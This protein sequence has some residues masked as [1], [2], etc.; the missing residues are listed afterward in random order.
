MPEGDTIFRAARALQQ[1]LGGKVIR[2][3]RSPLPALRGAT[4]EGHTITRVEAQGKNLV[5]HF[6]DGRSILSH[7]R[8]TGSWH[9]Y[10]PGER[11]WKPAHFARGVIETDDF[12]AVCF[13]APVFE[14][15]GKDGAAHHPSLA[16][17]GPDLLKPDFDAGEARRRLRDRN[18]LALGE[19]VMAQSA[20]AG[21]GNIFKSETLF[22]CKAN[23]FAPVSAFDDAALDAVVA[24]ARE[25]MKRNTG[26]G[27]RVTRRALAGPRYWVYRRSGEGCLR[28]GATV[29]MRRQGEAQRST[30]FCPQC[31]GVE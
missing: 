22:L 27:P 28:C 2:A 24:K 13:N 31:Q 20:I 23:P 11:W 29:R 14:L 15:L 25:L 5:I 7:M 30:Y 19:A 8:M 10:R 3:F 6:D 16:S 21:I 12:V 9:L 1:A 17:L 4:L 26:E 18:G